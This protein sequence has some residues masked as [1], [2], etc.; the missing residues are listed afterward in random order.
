M[1]NKIKIAV[2]DLDGTLWSVNSHLYI[3]NQIGVINEKSIIF[4]LMC[5]LF[6][7]KM[8]KH[9]DNLLQTRANQIDMTILNQKICFDV[10]NL[11]KE[12][13][14]DGYITIIITNAPKMIADYAQDL[15]L[16]SVITAP[17]G[18]KKQALD[19]K[20]EYDEL[21]VV[22]DNITDK[23]LIEASEKAFLIGQHLHKFYKES[24]KYIY[25]R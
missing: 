5:K 10:L 4:K 22:T 12:M 6:S 7:Q 21:Y 11:L 2:F 25:W 13:Q 1:R 8:K 18:K 3:L 9:L 23:D 15:F 20:Y 24:N 14:D 19:E 16:T 17:V